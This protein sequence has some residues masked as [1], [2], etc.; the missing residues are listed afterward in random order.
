[1]C[2][3]HKPSCYSAWCKQ[4]VPKLVTSKEQTLQIYPHDLGYWMLFRSPIPYPVK[5]K[6]FPQADILQTNPSALDRAFST[7]NWWDAQNGSSEASAWSHPWINSFEFVE[8]KEKLGN[9]KL[10]ICLD[11][12]NLNKVIMREP[13]HLKTPCIISVCECKKGYWH[14][15]LD[16]ALSFLTTFN[17]E[18]GR[19]RYI[20]MPFG[21]TVAGDVFSASWTSVL[22]T[23][24]ICL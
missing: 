17:T 15:E 3:R 10:G 22:D 5:S 9:I 19:F 18:L 6:Y 11:P 24:R 2:S 20:V 13:F 23:W 7:R 14:Q 8:G 4:L 16:E 21:V 12:T 1:M